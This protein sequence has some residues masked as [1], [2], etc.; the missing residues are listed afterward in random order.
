YGSSHG[1]QRHQYL[2]FEGLGYIDADITDFKERLGIKFGET[3]LDLDT[4]GALQFQLRGVRV[5]ISS[6]GYFLGTTPSYTL[7]RDSML[8]P[9][10]T[11]IACSI[12]GRSQA[13]KKVTVTDLFY[14]RGMDVGTNDDCR[15]FIVIDMVKLV[16]LQICEELDDTWAWVALGPERQQVA[17]TGAPVVAED[18]LVVD[19]GAPAVSTPV[20]APQAPPAAGLARI[21][22][23]RFG[24][25]KEDVNGLGGALGEQREDEVRYMSYSDYHIP[26]VRRTRRRTD[27]ASTSAP[28]QP[29]P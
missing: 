8:R 5:G 7:I 2:R 12:T 21:M 13:P 18:A 4:T 15:D 28:Q 22:A 6:A 11:L 19:E 26:Y 9:Y 3:V 20:Q 17:M 23:Q 10:H 24:R 29:D 25:L 27:D 14:L 16:R 1:D